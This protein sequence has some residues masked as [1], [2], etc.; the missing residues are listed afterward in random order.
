[1]LAE[2][3]EYWFHNYTCF[4]FISFQSNHSDSQP[5][6]YNKIFILNSSYNEEPSLFVVTIQLSDLVF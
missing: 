2:T 4:F 3:L 5:D 6:A 1:M